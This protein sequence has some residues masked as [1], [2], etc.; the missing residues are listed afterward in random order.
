MSIEKRGEDIKILKERM[1]LALQGSKTSVLDWDFSS[2]LLYV[3][4]SWKAMLGYRDEELENSTLTWKERV[5][6]DDLKRVLA[7]LRKY[8]REKNT[9]FEITHRL[10][11]R[12]GHWVWVLGRAKIIYDDNGQK[13]RMIGTHT[14][15]TVEKELQL[16]YFY[17]SQMIEQIHDSVTTTDLEGKIVSWNKGSEKTFGYTAE[18]AI[19]QSIAMLYREEDLASLGEYVATLR[20]TG[21]YN[22]DLELVTKSGK[23]IPISF[24]LTLLRDENGNPIGVVGINKDNTARKKAEEALLEQKELLRYQAHHDALT[25]L[26]N[27]ILFTE[28]L[29]E[30]IEKSNRSKI[31]FA[32]FFIDLD[33]FKDINDSLGHEIGDNVLKIIASR[34]QSLIRKEDTLAR[35]SGDEFTIIMSAFKEEKYA[36]HLAEKILAVLAEPIHINKEILYVSGSIGISIYPEHASDAEYLLKYADTA[37]YNAKEDG[38]NTYKFYVPEMTESALEHMSMKTALRQ[39]IEN[40]EFLI[41]Y[42]PQIDTFSNTMVGLEALIRWQHPTKGLLSPLSFIVLAEETGLI[43][44]IDRWMMK[45]AMKQ[46]SHWYTM[47]LNPGILALNLSIKQLEGSDFIQEVK[48]NLETFSFKAEWLELEITERQMMKKP[49]DVVAKLKEINDLGIGISIDDFGTGYSS[50]SLLKR[51][52]INRLKIDRSFIDDIMQ[53]KDDVAIVDAIIALGKS[54]KLDLIAEGVETAEQR[55]FLIDK[56]CTHMQGHYFSYPV[57]AEEIQKKWLSVSH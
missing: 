1:E 33:R 31:G 46:I 57:F 47:G 15:I 12:D 29:A 38:R 18:E 26:P 3:S 16:K 24:S 4:P 45:S 30:C 23:L 34:L 49:E 13:I 7:L 10:K 55:D 19:G 28:R 54:L 52:P 9:Y 8:D 27:R 32:L 35:L 25:Q 36:S 37:M 5:H 48:E 20:E 42:Q 14:D 21:I 11:H 40:G 39:A 43:V 22:A 6:K 53:D 56:G 2:N 51:L 44:E 17:Q 50:L 41:H